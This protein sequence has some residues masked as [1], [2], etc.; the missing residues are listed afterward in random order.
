MRVL[1]I[2]RNLSC[3][4]VI[5]NANVSRFNTQIIKTDDGKYLISDM[6]SANGTFVNGERIVG[7]KQIVPGDIVIVAGVVVDWLPLFD[8]IPE[9]E[10]VPQDDNVQVH[11]TT[12]V[13]AMKRRNAWLLPVVLGILSLALLAG[14]TFVIIKLIRE[15]KSERPKLMIEQAEAASVVVETLPE[16]NDDQDDEID[17]VYSEAL[18]RERNKYRKAHDEALQDS[19]QAKAL[20]RQI[21][22]QLDSALTVYEDLQKEAAE[23]KRQVADNQELMQKVESEKVQAEEH[24]KAELSGLER[25][26]AGQDAALNDMPEFFSL[27]DVLG[28]DCKVVCDRL[29]YDY[30]DK[31]PEQVLIEKYKD[32]FSKDIMNVMRAVNNPEKYSD[33]TP[34]ED[35]KVEQID[36]NALFKNPNK[37]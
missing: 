18:K 6:G 19:E 24:Y 16:N 11:E 36:S 32:G 2:G 9:K 21:K 20:S 29:G 34:E 35:E 5:K 37:N 4:H 33:K 10:E 14:G 7:E 26:I 25:I 27:L 15:N 13:K 3:D 31:R 23:L 22:S 8:N 12:E 28:K 30:S 1:T 17:K